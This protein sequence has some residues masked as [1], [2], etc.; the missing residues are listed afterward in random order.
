[1]SALTD[2]AGDA[3][4]LHYVYLLNKGRIWLE[5]HG[6]T[7]WR[8]WIWDVGMGPY[9]L[10]NPSSIGEDRKPVPVNMS[11]IY[12]SQTATKKK[13]KNHKRKNN[14]KRRRCW[15]PFQLSIADS[16]SYFYSRYLYVHGEW[17]WIGL[18]R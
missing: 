11:L 8:K 16:W 4:L 15:T 13:K 6:F 7:S 18:Y 12:Y 9:T 1:L 3:A 17:L 14:S 10:R 5:C 2:P